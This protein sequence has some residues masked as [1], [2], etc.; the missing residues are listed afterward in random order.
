[1][2]PYVIRARRADETI[3]PSKGEGVNITGTRRKTRFTSLSLMAAAA[4]TAAAV[5]TGVR[6]ARF[7]ATCY[8]LSPGNQ[9][10]GSPSRSG[11]LACSASGS[12]Y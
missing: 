8:A 12:G 1:V 11:A 7:G 6:R 10:F 4:L 5:A 2:T 3:A 9:I